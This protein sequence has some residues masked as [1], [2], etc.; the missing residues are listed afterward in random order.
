MALGGIPRPDPV[1]RAWRSLRAAAYL[2]MA[3]LTTQPRLHASA[4]PCDELVDFLFI[5]GDHSLEGVKLDDEQYGQLV[6]SGGIIAFHDVTTP[7][8]IAV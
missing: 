5:D 6:R 2:S 7:H 1:G 3:I 8:T 4:T